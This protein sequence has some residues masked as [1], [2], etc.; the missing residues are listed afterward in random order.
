[1]TIPEG[2]HAQSRDRDESVHGGSAPTMVTK[3]ELSER[4]LSIIAIVLG[5]L[6]IGLAIL[7]VV[8]SQIA[9]REAR[10]AQYDAQIMRARIEA[11]GVKTDDH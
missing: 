4:T 5:T 10:L 2:N 8:L 11:L 7:A 6:G 3:I 9:E 1:M